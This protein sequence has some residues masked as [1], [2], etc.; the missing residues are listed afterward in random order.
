[1]I[2]SLFVI[3]AAGLVLAVICLGG[4]AAI[5]GRELIRDGGWSI[6]GNEWRWRNGDY[7]WRDGEDGVATRTIEWSGGEALTFDMRARVIYAQSDTASV[8]VTGP[9]AVTERVRFEDGRFWLETE[10]A[11]FGTRSRPRITV[12]GPA[13]SRFTLNGSQALEIR[14]YDQP[15][16]DV[17]VAGSGDVEGYGQAERLSVRVSGSGD[18][19]LKNLPVT[20]A[21]IEIRGSGDVEAAPSGVADVTIRGSGD[22][23]L[24]TRPAQLNSRITGS[25]RVRQAD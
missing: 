8:T 16:L 11:E 21:V 20:D 15:A 19:D 22:V 10:E 5:G 9:A 1:M 6:S 17:V 25:G 3:A 23:A 2:R 18:V 7:G 12:T 13:V 24:T 4:A 14:D